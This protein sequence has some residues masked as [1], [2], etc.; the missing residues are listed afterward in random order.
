MHNVPS[1]C[2]KCKAIQH[3]ELPEWSPTPVLNRPVKLN[4][5]IRNGMRCELDG[6]AVSIEEPGCW[7][8]IV[9]Q[10]PPKILFIRSIHSWCTLAGIKQRIPGCVHLAPACTDC[11]HIL[12]LFR[13]VQLVHVC[14]ISVQSAFYNAQYL[15][16]NLAGIKGWNTHL[17]FV[18]DCNIMVPNKN[19]FFII[20]IIKNMCAKF[21]VY[22]L[23]MSFKTRDQTL[24]ELKGGKND[25]GCSWSTECIWS[26]YLDLNTYIYIQSADLPVWVQIGCLGHALFASL[27]VLGSNGRHLHACIFLPI[28]AITKL[29]CRHL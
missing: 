8:V 10:V 5:A 16:L 7:T 3:H 29:F 17:H 20:Y 1:P 12:P 26:N 2:P 9:V 11:T 18:R 15:Q 19:L 14:K 21:G 23:S 28:L 4:F 27:F 22:W 13:M 6:M 25:F 24:A